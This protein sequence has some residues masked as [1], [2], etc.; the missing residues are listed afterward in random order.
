MDNNYTV[1]VGGVEVN[2]TYLSKQ[3]ADELASEYIEEGYDDVHVEK[4][5]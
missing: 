3:K 4:I 1:W 2:D 5:K